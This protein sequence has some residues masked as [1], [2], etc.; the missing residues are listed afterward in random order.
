MS[1]NA[2]I[3]DSIE[4]LNNIIDNENVPMDEPLFSKMVSSW[5][6]LYERNEEVLKSTVSDS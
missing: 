6:N 4:G 3:T 5:S 2:S 1:T